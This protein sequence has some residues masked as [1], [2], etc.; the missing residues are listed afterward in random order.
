MP[1]E[2]SSHDNPSPSSSQPPAASSPQELDIKNVATNLNYLGAISPST[3]YTAYPAAFRTQYP[4][5]GTYQTAAGMDYLQYA[6]PAVTAHNH[7]NMDQWKFPTMNSQTVSVIRLFFDE[8]IVIKKCE[9]FKIISVSIFAVFK[10]QFEIF[11]NKK[12]VIFKMVVSCLPSNLSRFLLC[13][14]KN[15]IRSIF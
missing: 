7:Y 3:S 9:F 15:S 14:Q 13:F 11:C 6:T 8:L 10:L 5:Y 1:N 2:T 4:A 12:Y